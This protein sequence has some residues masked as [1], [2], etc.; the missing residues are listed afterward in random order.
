MTRKFA[1]KRP[2]E[3]IYFFLWKFSRNCL[4]WYV[5]KHWIGLATRKKIADVSGNLKDRKFKKKTKN[6]DIRGFCLQLKFFEKKSQI[7]RRPIKGGTYILNLFSWKMSPESA[8][9]Q[10][11]RI[12]Y[13]WFCLWDNLRENMAKILVLFFGRFWAHFLTKLNKIH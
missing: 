1:N 9:D 10:L 8:K 11:K 5:Q 12:V 7:D 6:P 2:N 13:L 3:G 4:E